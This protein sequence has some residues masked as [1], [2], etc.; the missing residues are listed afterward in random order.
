MGNILLYIPYFPS[1]EK[2]YFFYFPFIIGFLFIYS[3][4]SLIKPKKFIEYFLLILIIFAPSSLLVIERANT[5]ILIFLFIVLMVYSNS[6]TLNFAIL[7]LISLAKY[8]P[9][10]LMVNFFIEK[11]R[12]IKQIIIILLLFTLTIAFFFYLTGENLQLIQHKMKVISPT[13]GNQFSI[14][15][16]ALISNKLVNYNYILIL[17]MSYIFFTIFTIIFFQFFKKI[18]FI[19]KI[20]IYSLE[21]RLFILSGNLIFSVYLVTDN[22]HYR[23]IFLILFLPFVMKLKNT[24]E[25]KIFKY[26]LYFIMF[27][28]IFFIISNYFVFFKKYFYLLYF[29]AFF[30]LIIVS[31]FAAMCF[32]INIEILKK[33]SLNKTKN[34]IKNKKI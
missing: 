14:R 3:V 17:L 18:N 30:D 15:A 32:I 29:K 4:V 23:E 1:L 7:T 26:L 11:K 31:F 33:I 24:F 22:V 25:N 2:F 9:V 8:Y 27:R 12:S 28:Y 6:S 5:D 20:D 16:F 21:E 13:W 19:N 34:F 10:T